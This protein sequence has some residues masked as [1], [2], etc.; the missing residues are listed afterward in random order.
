MAERELAEQ[1]HGMT[2]SAVADTR[3]VDE[4]VVRILRFIGSVVAVVAQAFDEVLGTLIEVSYLRPEHLREPRRSELLADLDRVMQRSR[5]RDAEEICSRLHHLSE[6]YEAVIKP[7]LGG[8]AD[9]S[10]WGEVFWLLQE[11][12]GRI[13]S[14]V[15]SRIW[16]LHRQLEAASA[17]D[18]PKI[19]DQATAARREIDGMLVQLWE[20]RNR[21][22]GV[23]G[24]VGLLELIEVG[25]RGDAGSVAA[26]RS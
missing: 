19:R 11:H 20:L 8:L 7:K 13:I 17:G 24:D 3:I 12:E 21:I 26:Q 16:E 23:S 18:V 9:E 6:H 5:Y 14:M 1:L 15:Q 10:S 2:E 4:D 25:R 22:L